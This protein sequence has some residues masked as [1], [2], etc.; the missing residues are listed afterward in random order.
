MGELSTTN[1]VPNMS[2]NSY[3]TPLLSRDNLGVDKIMVL[4]K[5]FVL[6]IRR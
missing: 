1:R 5:L 6:K 4:G 3:M 2:Y